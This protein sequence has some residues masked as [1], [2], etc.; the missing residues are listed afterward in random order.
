MRL[1]KK[2]FQH[3]E[4]PREL[5]LT[6]RQRTKKRNTFANNMSTDIKLS[7]AQLS[8]I[9]QSGGFLGALLAKLADPLMRVAVLLAKNVL[10][11]LATMASASPIDGAIQRKM[12][13]KGEISRKGAVKAGK[14]VVGARRR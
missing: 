14:D 10:A 8:K 1:T 2:N 9:I 6:T 7:K 3:G 5:F 4:L 11:L 12:L 13:E